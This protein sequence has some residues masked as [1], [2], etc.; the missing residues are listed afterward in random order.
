MKTHRSGR[1]LTPT[2]TVKNFGTNN[3]FSCQNL[4]TIISHNPEANFINDCNFTDTKLLNEY[5]LHVPD[6]SLELYKNSSSWNEIPTIL[7]LS[8]CSG[9]NEIT[10][11]VT[12]SIIEVYN[13]NGMRLMQVAD[14]TALAE[15]QPG[16][17]LLRQ[18]GQ[19]TKYIAR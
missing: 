16:V 17:Y 11:I 5:T 18:D 12:S 15:L 8:E 4:K 7:P 6:E 14:K 19:T 1:R 13:V 9:I 10:T 2:E 3:F